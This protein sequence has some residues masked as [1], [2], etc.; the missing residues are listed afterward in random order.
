MTE[1]SSSRRETGLL[2]KLTSLLE[3]FL[4]SIGTDTATDV[5]VYSRQ[6]TVRIAQGMGLVIAIG[7]LLAWPSDPF[8]F[9]NDPV[10]IAKFSTMRFTVLVVILVSLAVLEFI[11]RRALSYYWA[12]TLLY[13]VTA[14]IIPFACLGDILADLQRPFY[15]AI[16]TIATINIAL[17]YPFWL[18]ALSAASLIY[19]WMGI[20][21]I[22]FPQYSNAKVNCVIFV[23]TTFIA[24]C[25]VLVGHGITSLVRSNYQRELQIRAERRRVSEVNHQLSRLFANVSHEMRTPLTVIQG[26]VR[27]MTTRAQHDDELAHWIQGLD[28]NAARLSILVDQF[29]SISRRGDTIAT[30]KPQEVALLPAIESVIQAVYSGV[31]S[32][33]LPTIIGADDVHVFVDPAHFADM[34]FNLVSNARKF[35]DH[36]NEGCGELKVQIEVVEAVVEIAFH[37]NGPGV[38]PRSAE[39]IFQR[40][41]QVHDE[42]T[43]QLGGVGLGLS[44]VNELAHLNGGGVQLRSG[45]HQGACFVLSLPLAREAI[46]S[47]PDAIETPLRTMTDDVSD[48]ASVSLDASTMAQGIESLRSSSAA[49]LERF[50]VASQTPER[51]WSGIS[52]AEAAEDTSRPV[53]FVVDDEEDMLAHIVETLRDEPF[54]IVAFRSAMQALEALNGLQPKLIIS[55]LMMRPMS[56]SAFVGQLRA[57]PVWHRVPVIV[58]SADH[59]P[60]SR[61]E[62]LNMGAV[63]FMTKPFHSAELI[64]RVRRH[65]DVARW[66]E[67]L[68]MTV[69]TLEQARE[70][71]RLL[72]EQVEGG[73]SAEVFAQEL[74]QVLHDDLGQLIAAC[75]IELS[76]AEYADSMPLASESLG[77]LRQSIAAL[78]DTF[79]DTLGALSRS[80][81]PDASLAAARRSLFILKNYCDVHVDSS[82]FEQL[83]RLPEE[84]KA[85]FFRSIQELFTNVLRH[86]SA[87]TVWVV[88]DINKG[89]VRLT[90]KDDGKGMDAS[91]LEAITTESKPTENSD[92]HHLGLAGIRRRV[93]ALRGAFQIDSSMGEGTTVTLTVPSSYS[94]QHQSVSLKP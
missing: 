11:Y 8:A 80:M 44:I 36:Q 74:A 59:D 13:L 56:G 65:L 30:V 89:N 43:L 84:L 78:T 49:Q 55:D 47:S 15:Y 93:G 35:S 17:V 71:L 58:V 28:R 37:D 92:G 64:A 57:L 18:R 22:F 76:V 86:G 42:T 68:L 1:H 90:V 29:L 10:L 46:A 3:A 62:L 33:F 41:Q 45:E 81:L 53:V 25:A 9:Q 23:F 2:A 94:D 75:S 66:S 50:A 82:F 31:E 69:E 48:T 63:D 27:R 85:C 52:H 79:R 4:P 70:K 54:R 51:R 21:L 73:S 6:L 5:E 40:F 38:S 72:E 39:K 87:S 16:Y 14:V 60:L 20:Q 19:T 12:A 77:R 91:T 34:V 67:H 83:N 61:V 7:N 88:L 32:Q 24:V 26:N